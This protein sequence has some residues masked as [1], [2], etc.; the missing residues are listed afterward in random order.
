MKV[1]W[2]DQ[3]GLCTENGVEFCACIDSFARTENDVDFFCLG[4]DGYERMFCFFLLLGFL[5]W[6][7]M[8][9]MEFL[10]DFVFRI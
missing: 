8:K 7:F 3:E 4:S 5:F 2:I 9:E 1:F 10:L 6:L